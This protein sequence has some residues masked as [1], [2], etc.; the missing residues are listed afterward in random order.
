MPR[1]MTNSVDY[2]PWIMGLLEPILLLL[3]I[4]LIGAVLGM[5]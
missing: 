2:D 4:A 3:C 1:R 5:L